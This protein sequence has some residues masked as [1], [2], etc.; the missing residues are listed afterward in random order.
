[1]VARSMLCLCV[2]AVLA[3]IGCAAADDGDTEESASALQWQ[4]QLPADDF[5]V[6]GP[7]DRPGFDIHRRLRPPVWDVKRYLEGE[8]ANF[9]DC[10][11]YDVRIYDPGK[12]KYVPIPVTVCNP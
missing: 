1:M 6:P 9:G 10:Y 7:V 5:Q 11:Q 2:T 3:T 8:D 4:Q 12:G